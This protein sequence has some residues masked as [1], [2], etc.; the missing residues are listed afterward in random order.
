ML[1]LD[2]CIFCNSKRTRIPGTEDVDK[3]YRNP[4]HHIRGAVIGT[5][6]GSVVALLS[7][8]LVHLISLI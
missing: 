5:I 6:I 8:G 1:V 3:E 7:G 4:W 2:M